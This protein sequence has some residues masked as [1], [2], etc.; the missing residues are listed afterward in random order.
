MR[1]KANGFKRLLAFLIDIIPIWLLS[2]LAYKFFTGETPITEDARMAITPG[3]ILARDGWLIVWILYCAITE[4]TPL[5]GTLG[6]Q[7]MGIEVRGPHRGTISFAEPWGETSGRSFP[8]YLFSSALHGRSS[9]NPPMRG[10]TAWQ[11]RRLRTP[12]I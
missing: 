6:K 1:R 8:H 4:C 9:R 3:R 11:L 2:L 7:V 10:M 5:R 12:L